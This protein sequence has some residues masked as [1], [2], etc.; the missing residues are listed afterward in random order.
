[1]ITM[2]KKALYWYTGTSKHLI[3]GV[4][5]ICECYCRMLHSLPL[6]SIKRKGELGNV[7]FAHPDHSCAT[8]CHYRVLCILRSYCC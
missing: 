3:H 7:N 5:R 2:K 1:M 4:K 6:H 8:K